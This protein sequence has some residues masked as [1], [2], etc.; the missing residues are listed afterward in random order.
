MFWHFKVLIIYFDCVFCHTVVR[1]SR[2]ALFLFHELCEGP[3]VRVQEDDPVGIRDPVLLVL[4]VIWM[5]LLQL[6]IANVVETICLIS[7]IQMINCLFVQTKWFVQNQTV[8][9]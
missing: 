6:S 7:K 1:Y 2:N 9:L 5:S 4:S 8:L 3:P